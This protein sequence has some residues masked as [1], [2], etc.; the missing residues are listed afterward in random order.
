MRNGHRNCVFARFIDSFSTRS[1]G[2]GGGWPFIDAA[3]SRYMFMVRM[4]EV[5]LRLP[6]RSANSS[7]PSRRM[8]A[9]RAP[10]RFAFGADRVVPSWGI[11][12]ADGVSAEPT[13]GEA[14]REKYGRPDSRTAG[15]V[16]PEHA[17]FY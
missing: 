14:A 2:I 7:L 3:E 6:R 16:G 1:P 9:A 4:S 17:A 5:H 8:C 15:A 10:K 12:G 13:S 11:G